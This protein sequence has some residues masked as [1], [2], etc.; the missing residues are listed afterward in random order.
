MTY[1]RPDHKTYPCAPVC[2]EVFYVSAVEFENE[3][4]GDT[5]MAKV[6]EHSVAEDNPDLSAHWSGDFLVLNDPDSVPEE[7]IAE[8]AS[9]LAGWY[10]WSC[11]PGCMPDSDALGPF[12]SEEDAFDNA[13]EE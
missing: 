12:R 9:G 5:W 7:V 2:F 6:L 11:F 4:G 3:F 10:W 1:Y 13:V 8:V